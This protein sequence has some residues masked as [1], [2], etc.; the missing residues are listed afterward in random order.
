M[1]DG[2]GADATSVV[3]DGAGADAT[4]V[5]V[6]VTIVGASSVAVTAAI[7]A[8]VVV[9]VAIGVAAA[10]AIGGPMTAAA[11]DWFFVAGRRVELHPATDR[12]MMGD[13]FGEVVRFRDGVVHVR[14][15]KSRKTLRF[16]P[17]DILHPGNK[18]P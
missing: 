13:R 15:D 11:P 5:V 12:W 18:N 1:V 10:T 8:S 2:A 14:L 3:V 16:R 7:V 9:A 4:R 17:D 6:A